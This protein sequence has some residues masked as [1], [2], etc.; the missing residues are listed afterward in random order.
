[1]QRNNV[2]KNSGFSYG[3]HFDD[4]IIDER[5][6]KNFGSGAFYIEEWI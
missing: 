5:G 6:L 1:M 2:V 3:R 4:V